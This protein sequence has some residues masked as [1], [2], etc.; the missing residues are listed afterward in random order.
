VAGRDLAEHL[1]F[2]TL[3]GRP[4]LDLAFQL[5]AAVTELAECG[6]VHGDVKPAN[7]ILRDEAVPVLVDFGSAVPADTTHVRQA[8]FL[9]QGYAPPELARARE[10]NPHTD[11][12]GWAAVVVR[13]ATGRP[14]DADPAEMAAQL[15]RLPSGLREV[16]TSALA[17]DPGQRPDAPRAL[18]RL[19]RTL[20][21]P[22][23]DLIRDRL[24]V[25]SVGGLR[26]RVARS[27]PRLVDAAAGLPPW[28]Y[29]G[30]VGIM[31]VA[32]VV[33]GFVAGIL[34]RQ[35]LEVLL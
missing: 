28:H 10:T 16:V 35:L 21:A 18:E 23:H 11:V 34:L 7:V 27:R 5:L 17:E 14:P 8:A 25:E 6:V 13:A 12:Y 15:D 31:A 33:L 30:I 9:T 22:E 29:R 19:G 24:P 3:E 32:G 4:L 1:G 26:A 2:G 20:P